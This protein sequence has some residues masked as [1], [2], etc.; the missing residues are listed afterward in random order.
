[1]Y[2]RICLLLVIF[3]FP[4]V[5]L[6]QQSRAVADAE[7]KVPL[8][9]TKFQIAEI[10]KKSVAVSWKD[11]NV[12][13]FQLRVTNK[14][15]KLVKRLQSTTNSTVITGLKPGRTYQLKA[16]AK[17]GERVGRYSKIITVS[18]L[19]KY[20]FD[21]S[22]PDEWR[23]VDKVIELLSLTDTLGDGEQIEYGIIQDLAST[24]NFYF[25]TSNV[26]TSIPNNT[27]SLYRYNSKTNKATKI[28]AKT[29]M[30]GGLD[31]GNLQDWIVPDFH[32]LGY[33]GKKLVMLVQDY[34]DSPHPCSHP[35]LL[36]DN[37]FGLRAA[38][39][40]NLTSGKLASAYVFPDDVVAAAQQDQTDCLARF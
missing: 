39:T 1:M 31:E 11:Q 6:P 35:V 22:L 28:F 10:N 21:Y 5:F 4:L 8:K 17:S 3:V 37:A 20:N 2:N 30:G 15:G 23:H 40:Y 26:D 25:A 24:K 33:D 18:T 14:N 19:S 36:T 38:L 34:S 16:R 27:V 9:V 29:Y 12:E 7:Y 32:V 13:L